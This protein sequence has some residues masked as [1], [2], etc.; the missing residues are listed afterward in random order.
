M[1]LL[2][3]KLKINNN[4]NVMGKKIFQVDDLIIESPFKP[5]KSYTIK[6][7]INNKSIKLWNNPPNYIYKNDN[8][9]LVSKNAIR[10]GEGTFK[11]INY[12]GNV[13]G[14]IDTNEIRDL[15]DYYC[16]SFQG[17]FAWAKD[18]DRLIAKLM[19]KT[20][21]DQKINFTNEELIK[22]LRLTKSEK[23]VIRIK[24]DR[25]M[26]IVDDNNFNY[27]KPSID[28]YEQSILHQQVFINQIKNMSIFHNMR[29]AYLEKFDENFHK[30]ELSDKKPEKLNTN[31]IEF[32]IPW[33]YKDIELIRS[34]L[35]KNYKN[36]AAIK[37]ENWVILSIEGG[38]DE[39]R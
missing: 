21:F 11:V 22:L 18:P 1:K 29:I 39:N 30:I 19:T 17:Y 8:A 10:Y 37:T 3:Y 5:L 2:G 32:C 38:E 25:D 13:V 28:Y 9:I 35:A 27:I 24:K 36:L 6:F 12:P 4:N 26:V 20:I 16:I 15:L 31:I 23:W 14:I 7:K 34:H 33:Q